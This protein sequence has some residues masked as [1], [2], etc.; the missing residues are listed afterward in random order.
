[1]AIYADTF[2]PIINRHINR[3]NVLVA[4]GETGVLFGFIA[5]DPTAYTAIVGGR[6]VT[7]AGYVLYVYVAG[8]FRKRGVARTLFAAANILPAQRFGYA[9]RT[10][11]SWELRSK[12]PL[13]EYE[14]HRARHEETAHVRQTREPEAG[15]TEVGGS[16]SGQEDL[17]P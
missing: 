17:A 4:H 8:P 13:A 12:I 2:R 7:L 3:T 6:R 15:A 10:R 16:D 9:C 11:S 1:M 14:P 5:Y